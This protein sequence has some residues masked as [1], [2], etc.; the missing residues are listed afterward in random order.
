MNHSTL[1]IAV[2]LASTPSSSSVDWSKR[3]SLDVSELR[4]EEGKLVVKM[5]IRNRTRLEQVLPYRLIPWTGCTSRYSYAFFLNGNA[6]FLPQFIVPCYGGKD[7][8]LKPGEVARGQ[9]EFV[10]RIAHRPLRKG[11]VAR[12]IWVDNAGNRWS[13]M[14]EIPK[15]PPDS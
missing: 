10:S 15:P 8:K 12:L 13:G 2:L 4:V 11:D 3:L 1:L 9:A 6:E 5:S 7:L 14:I